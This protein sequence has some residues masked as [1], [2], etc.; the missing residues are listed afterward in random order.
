MKT[1]LPLVVLAL[2]TTV[3]AAPLVA[4]DVG[5]GIQD[6][7]AISARGRTEFAFNRDFAGLLATTLRQREL[8][9]REVNFDG[10]IGSLHARP[11][12]AEGSDFFISIHHDSIGEAWLLDWEW[13]GKPQRY[14]EV[15]RGYGIFVSAQNPDPATSLRCA[16]AIGAMMRRAGFEPSTWHARKHQP[17]DAENGVWY[18]DNLVVLYRTG[19][20]AVLFEAGVIKHRDEELELLDP[21]RQA[22]MADAVATGIAACLYVKAAD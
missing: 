12:A 17:A 4:V 16:S 11:Q 5:H 1:I 6:S 20:P 22:R 15:K 2:S 18:Y 10:R 8:G 21:V 19:L 3:A 14:T 7:G 9:V 13:E